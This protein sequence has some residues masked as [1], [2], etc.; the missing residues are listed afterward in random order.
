MNVDRSDHTATLLTNGKVLV[1]GGGAGTVV[2]LTSAELYDPATNSWTSAASMGTGRRGQTSTLLVSGKVLI[3]GGYDTNSTTN[4]LVSSELYNPASNTWE[5]ATSMAQARYLHTATLL[6]TG[7]VLITGGTTGSTRLASAELYDPAANTWASAG[8]MSTVRKYHTA[9][10][11]A[12]GKV[13]VTGGIGTTDSIYLNSAELY[14]TATGFWADTANQLTARVSHTATLLLN[15]NVLVAGGYDGSS[16]LSAEVYDPVPPISSRVYWTA[17]L[18]MLNPRNAHTATLLPN[19]K[20]LVTGGSN[21]SV[22]SSAELY[23]PTFNRWSLC[24]PMGMAR[25]SH[26]ATL[27]PNG[28]VL[29]TGGQGLSGYLPDAELY[30]PATNTWTPAASM[31][32]ARTLHTATLLA[33]GTVLVVGGYNGSI[34]SSAELYDPATGIWSPATSMTTLRRAHTASLLASGK[35]LITG[36]NGTGN[37]VLASAVLY[38]PAANSWSPAG[39][40]LNARYAHTATLLLNGRVLV[41]GGYNT[42]GYLVGTELYDPAANAWASVGSMGTAR[43]YPTATLLANGKVLVT[44]GIG[45]TGSLYLSSAELYD[46]DLGFPATWQP[47]ITT[48]L[49]AVTLGKAIKPIGTGFRGY[50]NA[51]ASSG[52]TNSSATNYPLVQLRSIDSGRVAW[53]DPSAVTATSYNSQPVLDVLPGPALLT[54]FVNGIPGDSKVLVVNKSTTTTTTALTT[55]TNPSYFGQ[56]LTFT[57]TV[58]SGATGTVTFSEGATIYC[59]AAEINGN[60]AACS[61]S[62]LSVAAHTI[63]AT[64]NG[65]ANYAV[66]SGSRS[67]TVSEALELKLTVS[68]TGSEQVSI[69]WNPQ[70]GVAPV[71]YQAGIFQTTLPEGIAIILTPLPDTYSAFVFWNS[72]CSASGTGP[73]NLTMDTDKNIT[74]TFSLYPVANITK[75]LPYLGLAAAIAAPVSTNDELRLLE[76]EQG[77]GSLVTLGTG[78]KLVGGWQTYVLKGSQPTTLIGNLTLQGGDSTAEAITVK[79]KLAVKAGSLRVNDVR[80][81]Q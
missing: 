14:D 35:V 71:Y 16:Y 25:M 27:L 18:N 43:K 26:T 5:S 70:N 79:G 65:D 61:T 22:L 64:Y 58:T 51:E 8:S 20:V 47:T 56:P 49:T 46:S 36:G 11:L 74:A 6:A 17:T 50:G 41:T 42:S 59:T 37:V 80:V 69:T 7:K 72:D 2:S 45:T 9:T 57:A 53:L 24:A 40:Q 21:S 4:V 29:V 38:D 33:N 15:G 67:Q 39:S 3:S 32:T 52:G 81:T 23:N 30:D 63:T 66:S 73:C 19:G 55:G 10:L 78:I 44:G 68:G 54:F 76:N 77:D 1:A 13:L 60:I 28:K 62:S 75:E 31:A 34:L 12:N 48:T